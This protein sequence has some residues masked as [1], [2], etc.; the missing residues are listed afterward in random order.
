MLTLVADGAT[1]PQIA[2]H[3]HLTP[4]TVRN[5]LSAVI[6]KTSARTRVE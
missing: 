6:T 3:L 2:E 4:G 1:G 5:Y